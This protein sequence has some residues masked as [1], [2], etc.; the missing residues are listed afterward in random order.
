M[1][2]INRNNLKD[3]TSPYL[4]QHAD[5]PVHWQEWDHKVLEIAGETGKPILVSVGYATCH[6]CHVM[7]KEAFS[8]QQIADYLNEHFINI[9]VDREQHPDIDSYLMSFIQAT[10]RQGGW[11]LN[12]FLTS[13]QKPVFAA[14]YLPVK[15]KYNMLQL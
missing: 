8:D 6:W 14:T 4:R 5:N 15:A 9:K 13:D 11:P 7:V 3:S 2:D 10:G 1:I 12:V